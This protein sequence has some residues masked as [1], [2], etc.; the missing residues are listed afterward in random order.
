MPQSGTGPRIAAQVGL[1]TLGALGGYNEG[2]LPGALAPMA[3]QAL[4]ARLLMSKPV[5]KYLSNA[6]RGQQYMAGKQ[7]APKAGVKGTIADVLADEEWQPLTHRS[8]YRTD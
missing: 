2:G 4:G 7:G 1:Q 3:G 5:Q 6:L 8:K